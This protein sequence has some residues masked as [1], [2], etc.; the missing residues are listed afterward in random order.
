MI[1]QKRWFPLLTIAL[2]TLLLV[3]ASCD[4][5]DDD[6]GPKTEYN[7]SGNATGAQ[8]VPAVTTPGTGTLNG[9]YNN[10]T[11]L[12]TYSINWTNI[13]AAPTMMHFHGP[14]PAGANASPVITI[15]G[16]TAAAT[17][18]VSGNAT[19]TEAQETDLLNGL[20]YYN[21][22]TPNHPG[23]EIRAQVIVD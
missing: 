4:D 2:S 1:Q 12:L 9:T 15:T 16:F 7:L 8:E 19:L 18:S 14:A 13:K 20:W 17:G 10:T 22:H 11:N 6:D 23:G 5:D 3:T 21:L